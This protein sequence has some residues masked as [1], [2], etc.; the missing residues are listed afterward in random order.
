MCYAV[1]VWMC[2]CVLCRPWHMAQQVLLGSCAS[3]CDRGAAGAQHTAASAAVKQKQSSTVAGLG[4]L[5]GIWQQRH[6]SSSTHR[7][8]AAAAQREEMRPWLCYCVVD[9]SLTHCSCLQLAGFASSCGAVE[10]HRACQLLVT[11]RSSCLVPTC[12][13]DCI[14]S[15]ASAWQVPSADVVA[16]AAAVCL[17]TCA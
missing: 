13:A 10:L 2:M 15:Q 12:T 5:A 3:G 1:N 8:A 4:P 14:C 7:I 9:G 11:Q 17:S 16:A 6:S